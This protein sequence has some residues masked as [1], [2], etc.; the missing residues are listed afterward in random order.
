MK[1]K[2]GISFKN[3]EPKKITETES[4]KI[5]T[6]G[7]SIMYYF[8]P[9]IEKPIE[10]LL[11]KANH[12]EFKACKKTKGFIIHELLLKDIPSHR[13]ENIKS[14]LTLLTRKQKK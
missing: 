11:Y 4:H 1:R 5:I 8:P 3:P 9:F 7:K 2:S 12:K 6:Q 13:G 14:K 10:A